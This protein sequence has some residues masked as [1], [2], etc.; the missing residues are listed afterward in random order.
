MFNCK[1]LSS[2]KDKKRLKYKERKER[3]G[4]LHQID[5]IFQLP[6]VV[7]GFVWIV[8][9]ILELIQKDNPF[10]RRLSTTIWVIFIVDFLIKFTIA[11]GKVKFLKKNVLTIISLIVPAFRVFKLFRILSILKL[12]R[13]LVLVKVFASMN[14]AM[15]VLKVTLKKRAWGFVFMLTLIVW[16]I[17]ATGMYVFEKHVN[18]GLNHYSEAIWWTAML[19]TTMGTEH[20]P[21]SPEGKFLCLILAIYG[22]TVFGYVTATFAT[23]FIDEDAANPHGPSKINTER[24]EELK[25]E[26]QELKEL[27]KKKEG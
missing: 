6:M 3:F 20:W 19:I 12:T 8:L 16:I 10:L 25:K 9:V 27:I 11:P 13:G 17:G 7:L 14:Q 26:L 23:F 21:V 1:D 5:D 24:F 2:D 4:L 22:F 18:D 15:K